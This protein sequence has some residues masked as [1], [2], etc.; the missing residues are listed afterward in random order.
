MHCQAKERSTA[1]PSRTE[2]SEFLSLVYA[3][4]ECSSRTEDAVADLVEAEAILAYS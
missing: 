2:E 3:E 4:Q 1:R